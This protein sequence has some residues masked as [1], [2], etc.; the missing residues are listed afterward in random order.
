MRILQQVLAPGVEDGEEADLR[1]QMLRIA[2]DGEERLGGDAEKQTVDFTLVIVSDAGDF[3]RHGEDDMEILDR[4]QFGFTRLQPAGALG[5]LTLRT[6]PIPTRVVGDTSMRAVVA[7]F[8]MTAEYSG[9]ANLNGTHDAQLAAGECVRLAIGG[10]VPSKNVGQLDSRPGH[11]A[12]LLLLGFAEWQLIERTG[13]LP[14]GA[15]RDLGVT[16]GG[17]DPAMAQQHLDHPNIGAVLQ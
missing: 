9:A 10:A 15:R 1:A 6:V 13:G 3:L 4:Q 17:I 5:V 2:C 16:R 8:D 7:F 11:G 12:R 14:K